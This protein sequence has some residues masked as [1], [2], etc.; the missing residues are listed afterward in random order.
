M[1]ESD[2]VGSW[3]ENSAAVRVFAAGFRGLVS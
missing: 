3:T 1:K 2:G